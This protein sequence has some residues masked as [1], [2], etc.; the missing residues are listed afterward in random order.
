MSWGRG[1]QCNHKIVQVPEGGRGVGSER[2][3]VRKT[4]LATAGSGDGGRGPAPRATTSSGWKGRGSG[5]C[6]R[7]SKGMQPCHTLIPA[8]GDLCWTSDLQS[9]KR[10]NM[11]CSEQPNFL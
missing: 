3:S 9:E 10:I 8:W 7:A 4:G 1:T 2:C 6:S 11:R 5:L